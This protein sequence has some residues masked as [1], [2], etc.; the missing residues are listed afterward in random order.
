MPNKKV[1]ELPSAEFRELLR[2]LVTQ[3]IIFASRER[4]AALLDGLQDASVSAI[5]CCVS[6]VFRGL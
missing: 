4:L 3:D 1:V 6:G 2:L 5:G